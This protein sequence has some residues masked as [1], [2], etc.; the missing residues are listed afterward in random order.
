[1]TIL[2]YFE[3]E[4]L[5]LGLTMDQV[6]ERF[7]T[8]RWISMASN[9]QLIF[10]RKADGC[11]SSKGA[12]CA[13]SDDILV[14]VLH[15]EGEIKLQGLTPVSGPYYKWSDLRQTLLSRADQYRNL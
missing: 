5:E 14:K 6:N 8:A 10:Y 15:N 11:C 9:L 7:A 12:C 13:A 4:G 1:M 2:S 3:P